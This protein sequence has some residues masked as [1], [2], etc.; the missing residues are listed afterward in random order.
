L[1]HC[2]KNEKRIPKQLEIALTPFGVT[3]SDLDVRL[4]HF[5]IRL[6]H[7]SLAIITV[8]KQVMEEH[9]CASSV[10]SFT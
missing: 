5:T 2:G 3:V 4:F 6:L 9:K 10:Q 1:N 8:L 7:S